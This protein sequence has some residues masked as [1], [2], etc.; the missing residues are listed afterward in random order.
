MSALAQQQS[1]TES[2]LESPIKE[3]QKGEVPNAAISVNID[4]TTRSP[5]SSENSKDVNLAKGNI[6]TER[7]K[8]RLFLQSGIRT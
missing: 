3:N 6:V 1:E 4:E 5:T 2:L 7:R 8:A